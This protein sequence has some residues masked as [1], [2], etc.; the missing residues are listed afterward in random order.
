M[1]TVLFLL[2]FLKPFFSKKIFLTYFHF[3]KLGRREGANPNPKLVSSLGRGNWPPS[4]NLKLV[5]GLGR[6][7]F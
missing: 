3:F 4:P 6:R 2:Y 5:W 1:F 7:E